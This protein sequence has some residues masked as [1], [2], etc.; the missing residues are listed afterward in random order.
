MGG[1]PKPS[2]DGFDNIMF[3]QFDRLVEEL[4]CFC[5]VSENALGCFS[6]VGEH[7]NL[8]KDASLS[9]LASIQGS[10]ALIIILLCMYIFE[11]VGATA[12]LYIDLSGWL[13]SA[14]RF[15][16][17]LCSVDLLDYSDIVCPYLL[18]LHFCQTMANLLS[19][20]YFR[21]V[22]RSSLLPHLGISHR[23]VRLL[24]CHFYCAVEFFLLAFVC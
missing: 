20:E 13:V 5:S 10:G 6:A 18:G 9:R 8:P 22:V 21:S 14:D 2:V 11:K 23:E 3:V 1:V 24:L 19:A 16:S 15:V 7:G 4:R 12:K 17:F